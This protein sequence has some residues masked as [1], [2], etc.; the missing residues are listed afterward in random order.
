MMTGQLLGIGHREVVKDDRR[1]E[2]YEVCISRDEPPEGF[3]GTYVD[4]VSVGVRDIQI[5]LPSI[6][7]NVQYHVFWDRGKKRCAFLFA[8]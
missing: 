6:G 7:D 5:P 8:V 1:Y 2:F 3:D 4:N